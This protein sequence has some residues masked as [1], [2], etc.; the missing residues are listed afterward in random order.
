LVFLSVDSAA[1]HWD[2]PTDEPKPA[3]RMKMMW[4][5]KMSDLSNGHGA[6]QGIIWSNFSRDSGRTSWVLFFELLKNRALL[7]YK[8]KFSLKET[9]K[10]EP[11]SSFRNPSLRS[12]FEKKT[13]AVETIKNDSDEDSNARGTT[14]T[15][16]KPSVFF[17][18]Y[19]FL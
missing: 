5:H 17:F 14:C 10:R 19:A 16:R 6:W 8:I 1:S 3:P 13:K 15:K 4:A 12:F 7:H 11:N 18:K 2:S 9:Q